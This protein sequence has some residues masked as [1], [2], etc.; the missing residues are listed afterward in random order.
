[1]LSSANALIWVY[2]NVCFEVSLHSLDFCWLLNVFVS[3]FSTAVLETFFL[4]NL[5]WA[6]LYIV[7]WARVMEITVSLFALEKDE[8]TVPYASSTSNF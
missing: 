4:G 3:S 6:L 8:S 1:M 5:I 2:L 7:T